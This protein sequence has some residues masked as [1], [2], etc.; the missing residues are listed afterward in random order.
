MI[1][2]AISRAR[3]SERGSIPITMGV[4][5]V[6][7]ILVV[8][9]LDVAHFGLKSSRRAGDS[10]NALQL[11]DAGVNAAVKRV[12]T[13]VGPTVTE[14]IDLGNAG[15]YTYTANLDGATQVWHIVGTGVD[16]TGQKRRIK[17][18]A[19]GGSLFSN[20]FFVRANADLQSGVSIDSYVSGSSAA[21]MCTRK[22]TIGT[23]NP[24]TMRFGN[25][26]QGSGVRNCTQTV[27][28]VGWPHPTDGCVGYGPV[29]T[30]MPPTGSGKCPNGPT[31]YLDTPNP[32]PVPRVDAPTGLSAVAPP[33]CDATHPI[34]GGQRY[35]WTSV[36]LKNGCYVDARNGPAVIFTTG[37]ITVGTTN[38]A[39]VNAPPPHSPSPVLNSA[40]LCPATPAG[41]QDVYNNPAS[42]YC[43]GWASTLQIYVPTSHT[44]NV[45]FENHAKFWGFIVAP[46]AN[47]FTSHQGTPQV[48]IWG[49]FIASS[50]T[51]AA[52]LTLHYDEGLG[53]ITTGRY[54]L[55]NW[56]EEP[57]NS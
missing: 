20:A 10:A 44:P 45:F 56:R 35:Y 55:R 18:D 5:L 22:G 2:R 31:T 24:G 34:I 11:A 47:M 49:A 19:V 27:H 29:G 3:R 41:L 39:V 57:I 32:W 25:N 16:K 12:S 46:D 21:N 43:P 50:A 37:N 48:E 1:L 33:V 40:G 23:N 17:A 28:G 6:S 4:T 38:G 36:T 9:F 53:A 42:Y 52:Q 8:A 14:T 54:E 51:S 26:G 7:G 30:P 15:S 13:A